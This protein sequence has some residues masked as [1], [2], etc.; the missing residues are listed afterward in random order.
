MDN[1]L[2]THDPYNKMERAQDSIEPGF[3]KNTKDK[4]ATV[5][6]RASKAALKAAE[7][8]AA[9]NG[10]PLSAAEKGGGLYS[11]S[12]K[13]GEGSEAKEAEESPK[14]LFTGK[15]KSLLGGKKSKFKLAKMSLA[16]T[17]VFGI[18]VAIA[19]VVMIGTPIF[20]IGN[21]DFNLQ[22][23]LGFTSTSGI[24]QKQ[25]TRIIQKKLQTGRMPSALA[26]DFA[27]H[28]LAVG[29]VTL[30]GDFVRTNEYIANVEDL[31]DLA[32]LGH[33]EVTPSE[34]ELAILYD[35][36][37]VK[38][39]DFVATV[40]SDMKMFADYTEALDITARYYYSS[41]V[42]EIYRDMGISRG[43]FG[44]W[45]ST[46]DSKQ[47]Q[48]N[49]ESTLE[50]ML[51]SKP[52][53]AM[54]AFD[55]DTEVE[56][57]TSSGDSTGSNE[58][59]ES[60]A[61]ADGSDVP[62]SEIEEP[63]SR[64]RRREYGTL[65]ARPADLPIPD[66]NPSNRN[67][68]T[69]QTDTWGNGNPTSK[70]KN[71]ITD[72]TGDTATQDDPTARWGDDGVVTGTTALEYIKVA[73]EKAEDG[74]GVIKANDR[75]TQLLN[76]AISASEP[77]YAANAFMAIEEPI[78]RARINGD[79]PVN[80]LM[81]VLNKE[82][83][84]TYMDVYTHE[85]VTTKKS[86]LTTGN[87]V[88]AVS[89]GKFSNNEAAN[90]GRDRANLVINMT[91]SDIVTKTS[92]ATK[93]K[94]N[95]K[96]FMPN[97]RGEHGDPEL[98]ADLEDSVDMAM[99]KKNSELMT[100]QVGGNRI[101]EGG[102]FISNTINMH[103]IAA[104]PSDSST[105]LAYNREARTEVDRIAAAQRATK[106][107]FDIST[108]YTFMGS[109]AYSIAGAMIQS[110]S[111]KGLISSSM[112]TLASLTGN[113]AKEL[114]GSV[115]A[116]AEEGKN[117]ETT[118]GSYCDTVSYAASVVGDIYCSSHNTPSTGY[119]DYGEEDWRDLLGENLDE[120]GN[121][122]SKEGSSTDLNDFVKL[123]MDRWATVGLES[124]DVC[125]QYWNL[126][127]D[128]PSFNALIHNITGWFGIAKVCD[129]TPD[130]LRDGAKYTR[131][132]DNN[133]VEQVNKFAGF[134]LYDKVDSL[135]EQQPSRVSVYREE[136]YKEHPL[137]N[138]E[139]GI[140]ARRTGMTKEE[141]EIALAYAE[142]LTFI[143]RY[144]PAERYAFGVDLTI[145]V[146]R[147][148]LVDYANKVAVD[149]YVVWHGKTEYED[150]R[151][152]TRIV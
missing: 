5:K 65:I 60:E 114:V 1:E 91:D 96:V 140:I 28:G 117:Y 87:F 4:K 125:E 11:G 71:N 86:I 23:V 123:G 105:V 119:M 58:T 62:A 3:L 76:A 126:H 122:A 15:G 147:E 103:V 151:S 54:D 27:E 30:A 17:I 141:A 124:A 57:V 110:G 16:V 111:N 46:N 29:Q 106:S 131:S 36:K 79:G 121:I 138:S 48:Q 137:D 32:V 90:F 118:F 144:N 109:I 100:S 9:A 101:V 14:S 69:P 42:D 128:D 35:G 148:P 7:V 67:E 39:E 41:D 44:G 20:M 89:A 22:D 68:M 10:V 135:L 6:E 53:I 66:K 134:M 97:T 93:G 83:E 98:L 120:N 99:V 152:R 47:D 94:S 56:G 40:E 104:M 33:V 78:Q 142:Y 116:D 146:P 108:P 143:A 102:S 37:V 61:P 25:A 127:K 24:L 52:S 145:E 45:V 43:N 12:K 136:Y 26:G 129:H 85:L 112:G 19:A 107:P 130:G 139:V 132:S 150:L 18:V 81:N 38:A 51:N 2:D 70:G 8:A 55:P 73:A 133:D 82:T 21:I 75:A 149:L 49:F 115:V 77:Y 88:S 31:K 80:E 64:V 92:V 13:A 63:T 72:V 113:S 59:T 74:N 84:I 95:S 50:G 34:G